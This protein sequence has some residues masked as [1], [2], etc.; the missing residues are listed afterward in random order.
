MSDIFIIGAKT[1]SWVTNRF[2]RVEFNISILLHGQ[3]DSSN[4]KSLITLFITW[5]YSLYIVL[6]CSHQRIYCANT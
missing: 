2:C 4:N 5:E 1:K 6:N 3:T